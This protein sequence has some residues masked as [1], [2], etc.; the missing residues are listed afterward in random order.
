MGE[1]G[2]IEISEYIYIYIYIEVEGK[3][4][5]RGILEK[6]GKVLDPVALFG[7]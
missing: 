5:T 2:L 1:D 6:V 7:V 4:G 3:G